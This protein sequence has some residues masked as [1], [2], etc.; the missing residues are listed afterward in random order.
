[1][2]L[3]IG[4]VIVVVVGI[5]LYVARI[6][7]VPIPS[8]LSSTVSLESLTAS[9]ILASSSTLPAFSTTGIVVVD[10]STAEAVPYLLFETAKGHGELRELVLGNTNTCAVSAGG[11]PCAQPLYEI[12]GTSGSTYTALNPGDKVT[13]S[14][15]VEAEGIRVQSVTSATNLP[16]GMYEVSVAAGGTAKVGDLTLAPGA[17][18]ESTD[19]TVGV[20][21]VSG[22]RVRVPL[23]LTGNGTHSSSLLPGMLYVAGKYLVVLLSAQ[24]QDSGWV[25]LFAVAP[26]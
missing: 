15:A 25:Y 9:A 10:T 22:Q 26:K 14:G 18:D 5:V 11:Y 16:K 3:R 6:H 12:K 20:G 4:A 19:C 21:C 13:I 24:P 1:M 17:P 23:T 7:P 2:L 8:T